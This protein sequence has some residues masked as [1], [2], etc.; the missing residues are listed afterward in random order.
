MNKI[1]NSMKVTS[2]DLFFENQI[3]MLH[4]DCAEAFAQ[5]N[6]RQ[7]HDSHPEIIL[8]QTKGK[9]VYTIENRLWHEDPTN[10]AD[11][12]NLRTRQSFD[13]QNMTTLI[14]NLK[15]QHPLYYK[16]INEEFKKNFKYDLLDFLKTGGLLD[17]TH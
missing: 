10:R 13:H 4:V 11:D 2:K 5:E 7:D 8:W 3:L 1:N 15:K 12:E 14:T 9:A 17:G 6:H 16:L